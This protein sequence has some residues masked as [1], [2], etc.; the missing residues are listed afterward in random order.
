[1]RPRAEYKIVH[2]YIHDMEQE[3][4]ALGREGWRVSKLVSPYPDTEDM[5]TT[6]LLERES[7]A[8][9]TR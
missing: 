5:R 1:M 2:L 4:N 3:L 6:V 7:D 8:V 9:E